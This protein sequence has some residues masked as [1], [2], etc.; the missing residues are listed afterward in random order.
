MSLRDRSARSLSAVALRGRSPRSSSA[1]FLRDLPPRSLAAVSLRSL[2]A[3]PAIAIR[4][5]SSDARSATP[6]VRLAEDQTPFERFLCESGCSASGTATIESSALRSQRDRGQEIS[7]R[8]TGT[9]ESFSGRK[10]G[11]P[12]RSWSGASSR[13]ADRRYLMAGARSVEDRP[14]GCVEDR[15]ERAGDH[16]TPEGIRCAHHRPKPPTPSAWLLAY[17]TKHASTLAYVRHHP[18]EYSKEVLAIA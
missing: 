15:P 6:A 13:Q 5:L 11:C 14:G 4:D 8:C 2:P 18:R 9:G 7:P 10:R 1:T 17:S 16:G 3:L 12:G